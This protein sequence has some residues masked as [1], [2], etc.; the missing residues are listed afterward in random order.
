MV[1]SPSSPFYISSFSEELASHC[2]FSKVVLSLLHYT[3]LSLNKTHCAIVVLT[4]P[5]HPCLLLHN[6]NLFISQSRILYTRSQRHFRKR[7]LP[8][9]SYHPSKFQSAGRSSPSQSTMCRTSLLLY[10]WCHCEEGQILETCDNPGDNCD[11]GSR[12]TVR[13]Y[14]YCR[15]HA[16]KSF[17]SVAKDRKRQ[18]KLERKNNKRNSMAS[19]TTS[20]S[21]DS[22]T[23]SSSASSSA[24]SSPRLAPSQDYISLFL[25]FSLSKVSA[26]YLFP[27]GVRMVMSDEPC[28]VS[29]SFGFAIPVRRYCITEL[30][31]Y[32]SDWL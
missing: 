24:A 11:V 4:A 30:L 12:D 16:S 29:C 32:W 8:L 13:L 5:S 21:D 2:A 20:S 10:E 31:S 27:H 23:S 15:R 7:K 14:C 6:C 22:A 1:D 28:F 25:A 3:F 17:L 9:I 19:F 18:R 26:G